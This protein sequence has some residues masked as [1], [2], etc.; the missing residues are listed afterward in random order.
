MPRESSV[1]HGVDWRPQVGSTIPLFLDASWRCLIGDV[2]YKAA[3]AQ[4][5]RFYIEP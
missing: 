1:G 3:K 5:A 2:F 4:A